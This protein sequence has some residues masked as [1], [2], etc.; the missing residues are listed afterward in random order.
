MGNTPASA[1]K[2]L[3]LETWPTLPSPSW[4]TQIIALCG[5][6]PPI[7][8]LSNVKHFEIE[9]EY[10]TLHASYVHV[11]EVWGF[12]CVQKCLRTAMSRYN[13]NLLWISQ[14]QEPPPYDPKSQTGCLLCLGLYSPTVCAVAHR[15]QPHIKKTKLDIIFSDLCCCLDGVQIP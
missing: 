15:V 12:K 11:F 4:P 1:S 13:W 3:A 2:M 10:S 8:S 9:N 14:G 5:P 7:S 6:T